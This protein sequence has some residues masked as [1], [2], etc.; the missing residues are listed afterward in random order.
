MIWQH[1]S[2]IGP[3]KIPGHGRAQ[4]KYRLMSLN[5]AK[6]NMMYSHTAH[7]CNEV[8]RYDQN[9]RK[10]VIIKMCELEQRSSPARNNKPN[11][12]V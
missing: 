9:L 6:F 7:Q 2:D 3:V 12:E 1:F 8:V 4:C 10:E 11:T 5:F